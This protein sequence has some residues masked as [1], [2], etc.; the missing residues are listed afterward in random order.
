MRQA[1]E[2]EMVP[3]PLHESPKSHAMSD[4]HKKM[5]EMSLAN[6]CPATSLP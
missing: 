5:H 4:Y 3:K 6:H 2:A 1:G